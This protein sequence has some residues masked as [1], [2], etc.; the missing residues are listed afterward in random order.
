MAV[1]S[2]GGNDAMDHIELLEQ[3]ATT[4]TDL[5]DRLQT[6]AEEFGA[7]YKRVLETIRSR[8]QRLVVCTIYEPPLTDPGTARLSRVPLTLLNDQI[9]RAAT[10]LCLD[11]LDLRTVCTLTSDFVREIEP[12]PAGARKIAAAIEA[13]VRADTPQSGARI[14]TG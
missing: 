7:S 2:I 6:L 3:R 1:L 5:L 14:F 12:S 9:V 11:V 10:A 8:A 13:L 4:T